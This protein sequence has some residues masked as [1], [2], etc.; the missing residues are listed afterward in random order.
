MFKYFQ[1]NKIRVPIGPKVKGKGGG[2]M[3]TGDRRQGAEIH[4][5]PTTPPMLVEMSIVCVL[6]EKVVF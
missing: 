1:R 3:S 6:K 5:H 4:L 2:V